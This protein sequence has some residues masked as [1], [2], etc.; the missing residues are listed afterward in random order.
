ML[1]CV[2]LT[3]SPCQSALVTLGGPNSPDGIKYQN[4]RT[5]VQASQAAAVHDLAVHHAISIAHIFCRHMWLICCGH[6]PS[7][8]GPALDGG[9]AWQSPSCPS[10]DDFVLAGTVS[11]RY[12]WPACRQQRCQPRLQEPHQ[13]AA[14]HS[15]GRLL[16]HPPGHLPHHWARRRPQR[17]HVSPCDHAAHTADGVTH[18]A[19]P[20]A[21]PHLLCAGGCM[22]CVAVPHDC[23]QLGAA[24][25]ALCNRL[26][27]CLM[28]CRQHLQGA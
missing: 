28:G 27:C 6:G 26:A 19:T 20:A 13:H 24:S 11:L 25:C 16:C 7:H 5:Q 8:T 4:A 17:P 14:R 12:L 21:A 3:C 18:A 2:Q 23:M 22:L 9:L 1:S 15:Q 10:N